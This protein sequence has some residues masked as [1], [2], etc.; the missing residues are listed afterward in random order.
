MTDIET[1]EVFV[2]V[3]GE[4]TVTPLVDGLPTEEFHLE[5]GTV[6]RLTAGTT[7]LWKVPHR[8][9]KVYVTAAPP[10]P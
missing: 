5:P 7:A 9:R 3:A 2:V 1:E 10:S 8:L 6:C 4:G